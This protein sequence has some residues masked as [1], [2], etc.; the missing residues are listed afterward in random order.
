MFLKVEFEIIS[1]NNNL[2][3]LENYE[4]YMKKG[5]KLKNSKKVFI[6]FALSLIILALSTFSLNL[7][8]AIYIPAPPASPSINLEDNAG[9]N[10]NSGDNEDDLGPEFSSPDNLEQGEDLGGSLE[11]GNNPETGAPSSQNSDNASQLPSIK[12]ILF[13]AVGI[14]FLFII[15][16][17]II[18][19]ILYYKN[20]RPE[21]STVT[22]SVQGAIK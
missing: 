5:W 19:L 18:A 2:Y 4:G 1:S 11:Y 3:K 6:L 7:V 10:L 16:G 12:T 20:K 15:I 21:L 14:I 17:L 13:I 9:E 8:S 22:S